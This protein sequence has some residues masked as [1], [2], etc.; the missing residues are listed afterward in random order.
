MFQE[1]VEEDSMKQRDS[2]EVDFMAN[3]VIITLF[4]AFC[5]D[6]KN[7]VNQSKPM[8]T[9]ENQLICLCQAHNWIQNAAAASG[10]NPFLIG[11]GDSGFISPACASNNQARIQ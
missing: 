7:H 10:N 3:Q 4:I 11:K 2:D 8:I 5:K 9:D 6:N 1:M